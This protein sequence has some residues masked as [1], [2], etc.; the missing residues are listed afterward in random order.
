[1]ADGRWRI[2]VTAPDWGQDHL[3]S[4]AIAAFVDGE[5]APGPYARA[6]QHL[7]QCP[8]CDSQVYGQGQAS[9]ALRMAGCPNLSSTFLS[10]LRSI[11]QDAD[12][13][14]PPAGLAMTPDGEFVSVLRPEQMR[15]E[16][17]RPEPV[18]PEPLRPEPLRPEPLRTEPLRPPPMRAG[19]VA[20]HPGGHDLH[21]TGFRTSAAVPGYAAGVR[22]AT[23]RQR[24]LR[25]GT[26]VAVSGLALGALVFSAPAAGPSIPIPAPASDRGAPGAS[27]LGGGPAVL[28]A[29]LQLGPA[30]GAVFRRHEGGFDR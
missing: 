27:V 28:D 6:M 2:S 15:P 21:A 10:T 26:G 4:E 8:E 17:M 22:R 14:A 24:R 7:R 5:L 11:P 23:P 19:Q 25:L 9:A 16:P 13:P 1:V 30:P 3:S 12:L 18:R 20:P 29:R